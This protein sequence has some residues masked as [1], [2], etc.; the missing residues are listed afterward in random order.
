MIQSLK[1][2][3]ISFLLVQHNTEVLDPPE[4]DLKSVI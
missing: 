4:T 1:E 2:A 3:R